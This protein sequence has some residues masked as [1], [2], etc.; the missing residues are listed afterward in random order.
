LKE[1]GLHGDRIL[2]WALKMDKSSLKP[3]NIRRQSLHPVSRN[4]QGRHSLHPLRDQSEIKI[5]W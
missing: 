5:V 3:S 2:R 1:A 4:G